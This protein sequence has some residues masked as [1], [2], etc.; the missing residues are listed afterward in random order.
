MTT[1]S[2]DQ[3]RQA[4]DLVFATPALLE[5]ILTAVEEEGA[6]PGE[7]LGVLVAKIVN[8]AGGSVDAA[9]AKC[10]AEA[11]CV[12]LFGCT[13]AASIADARVIEKRLP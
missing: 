11:R 7:C 4:C 3:V 8:G 9:R 13:F 1:T 6:E 10:V 2:D 5:G 12:E